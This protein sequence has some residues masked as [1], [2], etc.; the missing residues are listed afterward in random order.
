MPKTAITDGLH[1]L[2]LNF[3]RLRSSPIKLRLWETPLLTREVLMTYAERLESPQPLLSHREPV[4]VMTAASRPS[5][6]KGGD[7]GK[8]PLPAFNPVARYVVLYHRLSGIIW[9]HIDPRSLED[10]TDAGRLAFAVSRRLVSRAKVGRFEPVPVLDAPPLDEDGTVVIV[11]EDEGPMGCD[12]SKVREVEIDGTATA[13]GEFLLLAGE[14]SVLLDHLPDIVWD[15]RFSA[16]TRR[17]SIPPLRWLFSVFDLAWA[18]L[19]GSSLSPTISKSLVNDD[20]PIETY[21]PL[22]RIQDRRGQPESASQRVA[23]SLL[24]PEYPPRWFSSLDD[25]VDSSVRAI[26]VLLGEVGY[27]SSGNPKKDAGKPSRVRKKSKVMSDRK[28]G[29]L[30]AMEKL[31]AIDAEHRK[32]AERI[33]RAAEGD[34]VNF[35]SFK[36]S[37]TELVQEGYAAS[38]PGSQ[39]GYWLT[40]AGRE[41]LGAPTKK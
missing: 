15:R 5:G 23:L 20:G 6:K 13:V 22:S 1:R 32:K 29:A 4:Q 11:D 33:A 30:S 39:G 40:K 8:A 31:N 21:E 24:Q 25:A 27:T 41:Y 12:C 18:D 7:R 2:E 36:T 16:S 9:D 19:P 28:R 17:T 10:L 35:D 34:S 37:L 38:H 14:A 3:E 26:R